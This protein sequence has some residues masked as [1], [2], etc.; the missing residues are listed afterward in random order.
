[1][2]ICKHIESRH[3]CAVSHAHI[4]DMNMSVQDGQLR[5]VTEEL[6][7]LNKSNLKVSPHIRYSSAHVTCWPI[8]ARL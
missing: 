4:V 6:E 3:T 5:A 8:C 2:F 7:E 1:M